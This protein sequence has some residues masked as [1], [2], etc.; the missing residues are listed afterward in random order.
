MDYLYEK[1]IRGAIDGKEMADEMVDEMD[2]R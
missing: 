1:Y 2:G